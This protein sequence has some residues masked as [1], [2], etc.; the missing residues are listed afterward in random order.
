[1]NVPFGQQEG[2]KAF[3]RH[4]GTRLLLGLFFEGKYPV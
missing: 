4:P 2:P 3:Q 1:M